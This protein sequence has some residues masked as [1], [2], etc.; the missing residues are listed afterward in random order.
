MNSMIGSP[1]RAVRR[2][3]Q[4]NKPR[5]QAARSRSRWEY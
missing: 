2:L 5:A 3:S 4:C 1:R